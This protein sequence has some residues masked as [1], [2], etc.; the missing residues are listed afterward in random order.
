MFVPAGTPAAII[1]RLNTELV[2]AIKSPEIRDFMT[3]EGAEPVG[4][5]PQELGAYLRRDIE[6]YGKVIQAG[7]VR[8]E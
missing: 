5:T 1:A 2:N 3:G 4:G 6:R 7:N 8:V